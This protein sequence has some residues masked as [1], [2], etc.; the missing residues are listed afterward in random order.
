MSTET[1]FEPFIQ[2]KTSE[3]NP[4]ISVH[5]VVFEGLEKTDREFISSAVTPELKHASNLVEL[6]EALNDTFKRLEGLNIFKEVSVLI[7]KA[8]D[9]SI[10]DPESHPVKLVFQ[11]K[12]K[13]FHIRTGTELQRRD[14]AWVN[15]GDIFVA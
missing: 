12:E 3:L 7:D 5:Q 6:S 9:S 10:S 11:C 2:Q 4:T 1:T 14:I 8:D 13:R 15:E